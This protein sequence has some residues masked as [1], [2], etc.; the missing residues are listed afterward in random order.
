MKM[1]GFPLLDRTPAEKD[2]G[3]CCR[4]V[5][6]VCMKWLVGPVGEDKAGLE[7]S[8]TLLH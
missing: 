1:D 7:A 2:Q 4:M 8:F 3:P 6:A 5:G